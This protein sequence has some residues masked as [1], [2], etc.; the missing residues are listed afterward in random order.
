MVPRHG[1]GWRPVGL[2]SIR[3]IIPPVSGARDTE[4]RQGAFLGHLIDR[5]TRRHVMADI[6]AVTLEIILGRNNAPGIEHGVTRGVMQ[7]LS[8]A[9]VLAV[10]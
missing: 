5:C 6:R 4:T 3:I 2:A 7:P 9:G 8:G 10:S 1:T